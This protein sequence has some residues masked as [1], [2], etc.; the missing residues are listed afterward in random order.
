MRRFVVGHVIAQDRGSA[1]LGGEFTMLLEQQRCS[2]IAQGF[3]VLKNRHPEGRKRA[4]AV[5]SVR[6]GDSQACRFAWLGLRVGRR[7][8]AFRAAYNNNEQ[9][10][11]HAERSATNLF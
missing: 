4:R 7:D 8:L 1:A 10:I 3:A 6:A 11:C 2:S 9:R 5:F